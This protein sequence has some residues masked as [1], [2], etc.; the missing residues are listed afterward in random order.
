MKGDYPVR[1]KSKSV[2]DKQTEK[3]KAELERMNFLLQSL[4]AIELWRGGLPQAEIGERL[5]IATGS[6]NKMLKGVSRQPQVLA[7]NKQ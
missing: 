7:E 5:G 4:L 3:Q 1:K 6:V 2:S